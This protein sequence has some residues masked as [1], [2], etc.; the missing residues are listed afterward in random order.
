MKMLVTMLIVML[1]ASVT[2]GAPNLVYD[3][4]P[5]QDAGIYAGFGSDRN[6]GLA[7]S[8][9]VGYWDEPVWRTLFQWDLPNELTRGG[10]TVTLANASTVRRSLAIDIGRAPFLQISRR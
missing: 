7:P 3:G 6:W 10:A 9:D 8:G 2:M 5:S 1:M 4:T